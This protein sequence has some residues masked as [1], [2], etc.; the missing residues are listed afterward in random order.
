MCNKYYSGAFLANCI[1][2]YK[3]LARFRLSISPRSHDSNETFRIDTEHLVTLL[4]SVFHFTGEEA[5]VDESKLLQYFHLVLVEMMAQYSPRRRGNTSPYR[6]QLK[7]FQKHV[8]FSRQFQTELHHLADTLHAQCI[9]RLTLSYSCVSLED[10]IC[11]HVIGSDYSISFYCLF[12]F[13]FLSFSPFFHFH[14][15]WTRLI[16]E[17]LHG[18]FVTRQTPTSTCNHIWF[19]K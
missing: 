6:F 7:R 14:C 12:H 15:K 13:F 18:T 1:D 2:C 16:V 8:V 11:P 5:A 10:E 17:F 19:G 9:S 3:E 4:F